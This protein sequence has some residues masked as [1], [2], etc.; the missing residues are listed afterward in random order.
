MRAYRIAMMISAAVLMALPVSAIAEDKEE[1]EKDST[2]VTLEQLPAAVRK[3][4]EKEAAGNKER[5]A[6]AQ[7][8]VKYVLAQK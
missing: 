4:I 6:E 5:A 2:T 7:A 1:K 8:L 3:T